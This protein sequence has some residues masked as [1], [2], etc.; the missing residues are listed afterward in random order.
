[1]RAEQFTLRIAAGCLAGILA[2][3]ATLASAQNP[4]SRSTTAAR[5]AASGPYRIAG[6]LVNAA[7]D[8]PVR[9]ATVEALKGD[10]S[11]AVASCVTD[12]EGHFALAGLRCDEISTDCIEARISHRLL[13][14]ARRVFDRHCDWAGPGHD[15][16]SIQ[17][18][19]GRG[20]A[21]RGVR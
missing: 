19:A 6:V 9:R 4:Q 21:W 11:H 17:A 10:D 16:T 7:T 20:V 13:R 14:R 15:A 3:G 2:C 1:M 8:E 18:D 12:S 5:T